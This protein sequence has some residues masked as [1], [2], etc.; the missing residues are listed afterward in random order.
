VVTG[1]W[2]AIKK[3]I[4]VKVEHGL[5]ARILIQD[6]PMRFFQMPI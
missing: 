6:K 3:N 5:L 2:T 1:V 4:H